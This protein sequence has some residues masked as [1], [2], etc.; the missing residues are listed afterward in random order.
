MN[1]KITSFFKPEHEAE[2]FESVPL[3]ETAES[4]KEESPEN[5]TGEQQTTESVGKD[6]TTRYKAP[7][8]KKN[9]IFK[10]VISILVGLVLGV[11]AMAYLVVED[12]AARMSES[13]IT[14]AVGQESNLEVTGTS[15]K[16]RWSIDDSSI[17]KVNDEGVVVAQKK[18]SAIITAKFGIKELQCRV[19]VENPTL[20]NSEVKLSEGK[21]QQLQLLDNTQAV[22]WESSNEKIAKVSNDGIITAKKDG[23]C[24]VYAVIGEQKY[25]C[26]VVVKTT[27]EERIL[28]NISQE[29]TFGKYY[30]TKWKNTMVCTLQNNSGYDISINATASFGENSNGFTNWS[31][32][33][34]NYFKDGSKLVLIFTSDRTIGIYN[35]QYSVKKVSDSVKSLYKQCPVTFSKDNNDIVNCYVN[36]QSSEWQQIEA[37]VVYYD[38]DQNIIDIDEINASYAGKHDF[39]K[40]F[41]LPVDSD[42]KET[43]YVSYETYYRIFE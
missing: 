22:T 2:M 30:G 12:S 29:I 18:G 17:A 13:K 21:T 7:S 23:K 15:K 39:T 6:R 3:E 16:A 38:K 9:F 11:G 35:I 25:T 19:N 33:E 31:F 14:L 43:S 26:S 8:S 34:Q 40:T 24:K 36:N 37:R 4:A 32:R 41:E 10:I 5:L 20:S 28:N 1:K 42:L 27:T